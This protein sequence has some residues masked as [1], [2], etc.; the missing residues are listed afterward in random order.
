MSLP[1]HIT[2]LLE[3]R[4]ALARELDAID[5]EL[6]QARE[7]LGVTRPRTLAEAVGDPPELSILSKGSRSADPLSVPA[8]SAQP[9]DTAQDS[10]EEPQA[11][12]GDYVPLWRGHVL[13]EIRR[14][15]WISVTDLAV[16]MG[17]ER[18]KVYQHVYNL[19][20]R[21]DVVRSNP[22]EGEP[23]YAVAGTP[24][25]TPAP[26]PQPAAPPPL[27]EKDHRQPVERRCSRCVGKFVSTGEPYCPKCTPVVEAERLTRQRAFARAHGPSVRE[28]VQ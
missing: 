10:E 9:V 8:R 15:G 17:R 27:R 19:Q 1:N 6:E 13:E 26:E 11:S 20:N 5:R 4:A 21:G 24:L 18:A 14:T 3:K 22:P 7:L 23:R 2:D 28:A 12:P 16:R 25:E